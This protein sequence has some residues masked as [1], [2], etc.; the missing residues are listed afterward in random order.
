MGNYTS[1]N[2]QSLYC[3]VIIA[4]TEEKKITVILRSDLLASLQCSI[5]RLHDQSYIPETHTLGCSVQGVLDVLNE[6]KEV[7]RPRTQRVLRRS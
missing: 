6:R 7:G 1:S 4:E 3:I 5:S 2:E